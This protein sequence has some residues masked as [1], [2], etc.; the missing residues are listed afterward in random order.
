MAQKTSQNTLTRKHL[1]GYALGDLGGCMT[2]SI[3]GSFLTRYY[4]NVTLLDT[5][6]IAA[7]TLVWKVWDAV[8]NPIMGMIMDKAF[9]KSRHPQGK[10]RPWMLRATPLL[11]VTAILVFTAPT[12]VSGASKLVVVFVSYLLYE[13]AYTMFNIPFGSLL[14]AMSGNDAER[15][16]LSSARGIGAMLGNIVPMAMFPLIISE[17]ENNLAFGYAGGVTVCAVLGFVACLLSYRFTE[18]RMS[19][20]VGTDPDNVQITDI[21][22]VFRKNRAFVAL[23]IHGICQCALQGI[24]TSL[25]TYLYSD[26]LGNLAMMSVATVLSTPLNIV[27]LLVA[28]KLSRKISLERMIR[29]S[30]LLGTLVYVLLFVLHAAMDVNIWV[31]IVLNAL[32]FG[33]IGVSTMMQWGLVGETIDYN[34]Y[35]TGKRTEGSIYGT[36]N[37]LRR[38]GQAIGTSTSVAVL[39]WIGYDVVAANAGLAQ[40]ASTIF[41]IKVM[42]ILVPALFALGSWAAFRLVWNITP[43]IRANIS[44]AR[45]AKKLR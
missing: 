1:L 38:I 11:A 14:S 41:G 19:A 22:V 36:F 25:G 32:A 45:S 33:A 12:M 44:D 39:G 16:A 18:E 37:M 7:L 34:E 31:H 26:V 17:F 21:F 28:P 15:A 10:F 27:V 30:L 42:C 2:F 4:V 6:V 35:L 23:C 3:M 5:A 20:A 40:S 8:S 24:S 9:A 13:A 29:D 43:E